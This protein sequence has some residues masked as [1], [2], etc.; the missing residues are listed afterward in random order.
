MVLVPDALAAEECPLGEM[1]FCVPLERPFLGQILH[2]GWI[3]L[4]ENCNIETNISALHK[5]YHA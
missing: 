3:P 2:P 5:D 4:A 1:T